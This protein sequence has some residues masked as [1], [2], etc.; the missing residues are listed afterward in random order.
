M[1]TRVANTRRFGFGGQSLW[2]GEDSDDA[3]DADGEA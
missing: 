2:V 3:D 1:L